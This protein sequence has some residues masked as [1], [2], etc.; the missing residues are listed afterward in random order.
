MVKVKVKVKVKVSGSLSRTRTFLQRLPMFL[1]TTERRQGKQKCGKDGKDNKNKGG[2]GKGGN[3]GKGKDKQDANAPQ[4]H[5]EIRGQTGTTRKLGRTKSTDTFSSYRPDQ[6]VDSGYVHEV[7]G[8]D[9]WGRRLGMNGVQLSSVCLP[10]GFGATVSGSKAWFPR[11]Q[12]AQ[13]ESTGSPG[14]RRARLVPQLRLLPFLIYTRASERGNNDFSPRTM[15]FL[16]HGQLRNIVRNGV[17]PQ[18]DTIA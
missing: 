13:R 5:G 15:L 12:E 4:V 18:S 16:Q 1:G 2:K 10:H 11:R 7:V 6:I 17:Q 3:K 14:E 9:S 8:E